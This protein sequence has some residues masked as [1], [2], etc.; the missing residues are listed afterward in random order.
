MT[1]EE[2]LNYDYSRIAD[3][4]L[5]AGIVT[6][7]I[8]AMIIMGFIWFKFASKKY[9][10][11]LG[12]KIA[13]AKHHPAAWVYVNCMIGRLWLITG[14]VLGLLDA[15]VMLRC[16]HG[17]VEVVTGTGV[18]LL[19]VELALMVCSHFYTKRTAKKKFDSF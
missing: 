11:F 4:L 17:S 1:M 6:V 14:F 5:I 9:N 8:A 12:Y 10:C 2:L 15:F 7:A 3:W 19:F 18:L 16:M 13:V